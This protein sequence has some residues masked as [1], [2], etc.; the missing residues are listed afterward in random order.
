MEERSQTSMHHA[1][2][3]FS[4]GFGLF[5]LD[6]TPMD[7]KQ[8]FCCGHTKKQLNAIC[9]LLELR[10]AETQYRGEKE[11]E[12]LFSFPILLLRVDERCGQSSVLLPVLWRS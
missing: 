6:P 1:P 7:V 3:G 4:S 10:Q 2:G 8:Q 12:D 11:G 9:L 5:D